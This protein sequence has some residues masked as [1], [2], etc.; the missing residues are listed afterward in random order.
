MET[1]GKFSSN[2]IH[3]RSLN[4][5]G[6]DLLPIDETF[7]CVLVENVKMNAEGQLIGEKSQMPMANAKVQ[8]RERASISTYPVIPYN[9]IFTKH[10]EFPWRAEAAYR[11]GLMVMDG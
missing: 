11:V 10:C 4:E 2:G 8:H 3:A 7:S 1:L 9:T 6:K 5:V